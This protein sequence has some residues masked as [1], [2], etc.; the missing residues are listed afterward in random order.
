MFIFLVAEMDPFY[1][2][3]TSFPTVIFTF[4]LALS[5]LFWLVA[6]LGF[7]DIEVLDFD[8]PDLDGQLDMNPDTGLSSPDALAGLMLK[9]GLNSVPVTIVVSLISLI[10][11]FL[12]YYCV[13][14]VFPYIPEGFLY[15]LAGIAVFVGVLITAALMTSVVIRPLRPLFK[16]AQTQSV[17]YIVGQTAVVRTSRVD[18]E[19]GEALLEDGGAGLI[20]KVRTIGEAR[21]S[22]GDRVVLFEY[23]EANNYYR[24]ISE[25]EFVGG[26]LDP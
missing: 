26:T 10:G 19:F 18:H 8:L 25:Q 13:H 21:F 24:V 4:M 22:K 17:K 1:L 15:Y 2:N 7:I 20:L 14:F 11:W 16:N 9:F 5:T 12:C 3:I 23:V 6:V